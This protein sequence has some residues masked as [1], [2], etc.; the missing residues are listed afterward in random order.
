MELTSLGDPFNASSAL[1]VKLWPKRVMDGSSSC[2]AS[3]PRMHER[4]DETCVVMCLEALDE[5]QL[6]ICCLDLT[7]CSVMLLIKLM[8]IMVGFFAFLATCLSKKQ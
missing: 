8:F 6:Q 2:W 3:V 4:C 1:R 5:P 7:S